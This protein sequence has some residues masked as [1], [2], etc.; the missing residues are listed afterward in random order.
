M[1]RES[2]RSDNRKRHI[3]LLNLNLV[4]LASYQSHSNL[5]RIT[6]VHVKIII[7]KKAG[8]S[9]GPFKSGAQRPSSPDGYSGPD[10]GNE[11]IGC[12][13][14]YSLFFLRHLR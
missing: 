7:K 8:E 2:A 13:S 9:A 14:G 1:L 5:D 3:L 4:L 10:V 12:D 6:C 11:G